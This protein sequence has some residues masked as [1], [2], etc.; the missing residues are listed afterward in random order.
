MRGGMISST[1]LHLGVLVI[2]VIGLPDFGRDLEVAPPIPVEIATIDELTRPKPSKTPKPQPK[3]AEPE[4]PQEIPEAPPPPPRQAAPPPPPPPAPAPEPQQAEL[5]KPAPPEPAPEPEPEPLPLPEPEA[6]PE[7]KEEVKKEEPKP[8][9]P[10]PRPNRK[11]Q[12]KLAQKPEKKKEEP[13]VDQLAQILK[14]VEKLKEEE[15]ATRRERTQEPPRAQQ[16]TSL[17]SLPMSL[18][19]I[20]AVKQQIWPCWSPPVG[21]PQAEKLAVKIKLYLNQDGSLQ[22]AQFVDGLRIG[23]DRFY[24]IAAEA[25]MRAVRRCTPLQRLP[26]KKYS[27]WREMT[28]NFDPS[29]ILG[30]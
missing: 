14:D 27:E 28:L 9:P 22:R 17:S 10:A 12:V 3:A 13:K 20:D 15:P 2:L 1:L 5:P 8:Q 7:P 21:A 16:Q 29:E 11:P 23:G 25:A 24:R 30:Q 6:K 19:E 4:E 18:S 26:P